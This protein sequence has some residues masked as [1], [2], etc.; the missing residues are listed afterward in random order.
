M[1]NEELRYHGTGSP[2]GR[3]SSKP[4]WLELERIDERHDRT[5]SWIEVTLGFN[6]VIRTGSSPS[7][8]TKASRHG[9]RRTA[10]ATMRAI[11]LFF[12]Y[13]F[14][15]ELV[16]VEHVFVLGA[17]VIAVRVAV[18]IDGERVELFGSARVD[19]DLQEAAAN[20]VLDATN[21]YIDA[22]LRLP[23]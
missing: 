16:D 1:E 18:C 23:E 9:I 10:L 6:E 8:S 22:V 14:T 11:E 7:A 4:I 12:E 17:S 5:K 13:R 15:C 20:A 3:L 19:V 21:R 2:D